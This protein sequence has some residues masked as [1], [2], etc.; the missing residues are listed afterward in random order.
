M[1]F[2][3]IMAFLTVVDKGTISAAAEELFLTQSTVSTRIKLLEKELGIPLL[4]RQQGKRTIALTKYGREFVPIAEKIKFLYGKSYQL[5]QTMLY[6]SLSI[7]CVDNVLNYTLMPYFKKALEEMPS[8]DL[9]LRT[10]HSSEIYER[11]LEFKADMGIIWRPRVFKSVLSK[12][13]Y[14]ENMVLICKSHAPYYEGIHPQA[15]DR[16]QEIHI[17]WHPDYEKWYNE[18]FDV[19]K[20]PYITVN[21]GSAI[22]E[23]LS[24][25]HKWAIV[26]VSIAKALSSTRDYTYYSLPPNTPKN[27]CYYVHRRDAKFSDVT[28][29]F[30]LGL[31]QYL[32]ACDW[33]ENLLQLDV[34]GEEEQ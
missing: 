32:C 7:D 12:P 24:D 3:Y 17:D 26:P 18:H 25:E 20:K 13:L 6:D 10:F 2:D 21:T 11:I 22:G 34:D 8:L 9:T 5:K 14:R 19:L 4:E 27:I 23:Y 30:I 1:N 29:K 31:H 16:R 28:R 15:L 33:L